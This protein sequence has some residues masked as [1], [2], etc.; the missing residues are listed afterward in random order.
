MFPAQDNTIQNNSINTDKTTIT[1]KSFLFN[2]E[3]GDFVLDATGKLISINDLEALK[4]WIKKIL[5]T[6]KN[7]FTVYDGTDY[8]IVNLKELITSDYPFEF[9]KSEIE[10]NVKEVLL[11]NT[12]IKSVENF[13]FKRNKRLLT[14][15][16]D[17]S[18]IYGTVQSEVII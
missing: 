13:E 8:G 3:A 14:V 2:F 7:K 12:A 16:F 18:T 10:S 15:S 4:I 9:I 6:D 17:C 5:K 1:G 11:K